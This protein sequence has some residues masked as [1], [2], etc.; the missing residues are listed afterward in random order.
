[1][2]RHDVK[3]DACVAFMNKQNSTVQV[4]RKVKLDTGDKRK[5]KEKEK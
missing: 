5:K 1:M 3:L 4:R 2:Q